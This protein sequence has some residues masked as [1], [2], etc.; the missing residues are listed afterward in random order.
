MEIRTGA[1]SLPPEGSRTA[2]NNSL[3]RNVRFSPWLAFGGRPETHARSFRFL[4]SLTTLRNTIAERRTTSCLRRAISCLQCSRSC[5]SSVI[6]DTSWRFPLSSLFIS[7]LFR[8]S[9]RERRV[10]P[11]LS[12]QPLRS[13]SSVARRQTKYVMYQQ[14]LYRPSVLLRPQIGTFRTATPAIY[15][16][17][18]LHRIWMRVLST[19]LSLWCFQALTKEQADL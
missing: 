7:H 9:E 14:F 4:P 12:R 2:K 3:R 11:C 18:V 8:P 15:F 6:T 1:A 13:K 10:S 19:L 5:C 17:D 16:R